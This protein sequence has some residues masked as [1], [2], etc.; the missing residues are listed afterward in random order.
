[1]QKIFSP[2]NL[3]YIVYVLNI[4]IALGLIFVDRRKTPTATLAWIMIMFLLPYLGLILYCVFSQN[5]ARK[6]IYTMNEETEA[7]SSFL[8]NNQKNTI[9]TFISQSHNPILYKWREMILMNIEYSDSLLTQN[10]E[11]ETIFD[12]NEMFNRLCDE[13][14]KA[15]YTIKL[16]YFI[17]KNDYVG[18]KFIKLLTEKAK[19]GVKVRLLIDALGS[20]G[21]TSN[22]L[23]NFKDAGGEYAFFFKPKIRHL[24]INFNYRNH[25]KMAI[26]DNEIGFI[27]GFNIAKEYLGYKRKFGYW[28]DTQ[29]VIK[30]NSLFAMNEQFYLDWFSAN[31]NVPTFNYLEH[32]FKYSFKEEI[33]NIPMQIVSSGPASE[34]E[35][36]K[37]AMMKMI[38]GAR[39][40]IYI[41]T[42]YLVPDEPFLESICM[43][44]RSGVDVKIMIPC[45]PDHPFVYRTTL[46]NAGRL[47]NEGVKIYIYNNGFLH[48]KT[49]T[50]DGEVTTVGSTNMDIRSFKLNF[51][52]NAFIYD[53]GITFNMDSQF[54]KDLESCSEYTS[55]DRNNISFKEQLLES[56]SRL[57]QEIL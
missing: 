13:I 26:I 6:K 50:I 47:I 30:G 20:K 46:Y 27:G 51:E 33:G 57:L 18:Q 29:L 36:I 12:G 28:R 25:R 4:I 21:I 22:V 35:E 8:L 41:Q 34:K 49:M 40:N 5:I 10:T 55:Y 15:K 43:A 24:F 23:K 45:M 42:P 37:R 54:K 48:A 17:V 9:R 16:E 52:S 31:K 56:I 14:K 53:D 38:N 44:A 19:Q 3:I 2:A 39:E 1:M 11:I 32:S 7:T